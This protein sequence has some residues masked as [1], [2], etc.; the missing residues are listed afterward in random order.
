MKI[1]YWIATVLFS[2]ILLGSAGFYLFA[3]ATV[4]QNF[5][6]LHYP[7][8]LI[9]PL[10]AAKILGVAAIL[11]RKSKTLTEW[12]YAGFFFELLLAASAH[13][14]ANVPSPL[15]ALVALA[16]LLISYFLGKKVYP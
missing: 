15:L 2:L 3:H 9:Y 10:A 7:I 14:F 5:E 1:I 16:L 6:S 11:S 4:V 8:Y 13:V 12:A